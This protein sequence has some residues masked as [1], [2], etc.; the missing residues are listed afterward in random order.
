MP[1]PV[2]NQGSGIGLSIVKEFVQL[3]D[4][5]IT[6]TSTLGVGSCFVVSIPART[7]SQEMLA[8]KLSVNEIEEKI[9]PT[10]KI[11]DANGNRPGNRPL[12]LIAEDNDEFRQFLKE[13]LQQ[14]YRVI[15]ASNGEEAWQQLQTQTPQ[16]VISDVM[17]PVMNGVELAQKIKKNPGTAAIPVLLLTAKNAE[18]HQL[19]GLAT[20]ANDYIVKPFSLEVLLQKIKNQLKEQKRKPVPQVTIVSSDIPAENPEQ[21]WLQ[22][23]LAVVESNIG[24]AEF[25][26]KDLARSVGMSRAGLYKKMLGFAGKSPVEFIIKVRIERAKQ[27]LIQ[28]QLTVAEVAYEVG[29][30]DPKYF[31]KTFKKDTGILPSAFAA[32]QANG[33]SVE[34]GQ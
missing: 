6:V 30:T 27:L 8:P 20:G 21:K 15:T 24:N 26:V 1:G 4:G 33:Q 11:P 10:S 29:F 32:A 14:Y 31:A 13:S 9:V 22:Q 18:E 34:P 16:L 23:V 7:A 19:E 17:M 5:T 28:Q 12:V 3:H 2:I 25:S